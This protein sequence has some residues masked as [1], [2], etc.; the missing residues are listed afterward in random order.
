MCGRGP[1]SLVKAITL[2]LFGRTNPHKECDD[3][4][5]GPVAEHH[6]PSPVD[7]DVNQE[8]ISVIS[9]SSSAFGTKMVMIAFPFHGPSHISSKVCIKTKRTVCG[10]LY[11][12]ILYHVFILTS[13]KKI[14]G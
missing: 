9:V 11:L 2:M 13:R 7:V 3:F 8:K 10:E 12:P 1:L 6:V 4:V 5:K 14:C